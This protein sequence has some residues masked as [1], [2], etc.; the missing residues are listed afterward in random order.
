MSIAISADQLKALAALDTCTVANAIE[1]FDVRLRNVGYASG[2]IRC[3][4]PRPASMVGYAATVRI[5][6]SNPP[7]KGHAFVDR[8]DW[9][10]FVSTIPAPRVI[11]I[12]D[13]DERP[14]AGAFV[15]EVHA[16]ILQA[17]GCVGAVTNGAVRDVPSIERAGFQLFARSLSVSHA[18][19]HIIDYGREVN[20]GGL[21]VQPGDLLHAD[22]H[23]VLSVPV[24]IA[25][26]IPQEAAAIQERELRV[27]DLCR[28]KDFSI[29]KLR[30]AVKG[31]FD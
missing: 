22:C 7:M 31:V 13:M 10:N 17:L 6:C 21:I 28:S 11:V 19:V 30:A 15:G 14:G 9:W 3:L 16:A 5:R 12:E 20:V 18:Y 26:R 8:T 25:A 1:R 4:T 29:E 27:I 23:G 2:D 24:E